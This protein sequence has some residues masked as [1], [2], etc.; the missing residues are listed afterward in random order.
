MRIFSYYYVTGILF[1]AFSL[2]EFDLMCKVIAKCKQRYKG[3][4]TYKL[5]VPLLKFVYAKVDGD[6]QKQTAR[7]KKHVSRVTA[8]WTNRKHKSIIYLRVH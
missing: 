6:M 4:S 8:G 3:P 5:Y 1:H 7:S 2:I